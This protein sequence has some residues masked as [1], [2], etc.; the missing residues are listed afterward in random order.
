M[1]KVLKW[2]DLNAEVLLCGLFF[3]AILIVITVQIVMRN[4]VGH[5]LNWAEEV[6]RYLHVWVTY[7]GL[8]YA[9]RMNSH[10]QIDV[11]RQ[12][13]PEKVQKVIM[14]IIQ[15]ILLALFV[16][17]FVGSLQVC[18]KVA[19]LNNRA[20]SMN[21]S[22]N[23]MYI[24]A[25]LGLGFC[26]IRLFQTLRWKVK[27]FNKSWELFEDKEG[28]YSGALETFCY[29]EYVVEELKETQTERALKEL[30]EMNAKKK[31]GNK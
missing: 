22:Q 11:F 13:L 1:K 3:A 16:A 26:I 9:T 31:G 6:T 17:L 28:V 21:V 25:P 24:S 5:G 8:S 12:R 20:E 7:I 23:W 18:I 30:E 4:I 29:P 2:L 14:V 27:T 10:I 15:L 19:T